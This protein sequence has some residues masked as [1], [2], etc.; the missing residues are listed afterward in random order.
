VQAT[1]SDIVIATVLGAASAALCGYLCLLLFGPL[2]SSLVGSRQ[3]IRLK[4][5]SVRIK[6]AEKMI[7]S[8][9][10]PQAVAELKKAVLLDTS[11]PVALLPAVRDHNQNLLSCCVTIAE[12]MNA[13][14][15]NLPGVERLFQQRVELLN[16]QCKAE[17]AF[18]KLRSRRQSAGKE[19][20]NWSQNDFSGRLKEI[21]KEL[22]KN[23]A[24]LET[25]LRA[26]FVEIVAP[27][28]DSVTIH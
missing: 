18:T 26:L 9:Q 13:R 5:A 25:A 21:R 6:N 20:P 24:E 22:E 8:H 11:F 17:E 16:L 28:N 14:P 23:T 3:T 1:I 15:A 19:I 4:R 10:Y 27:V 12:E 2:I 7:D